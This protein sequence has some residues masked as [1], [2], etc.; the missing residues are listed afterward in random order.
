[1]MDAL[2]H[3]IDCQLNRGV[4]LEDAIRF[5]RPDNLAAIRLPPETSCVAELLSF[6][7]VGFTASELPSQEFI[8]GNVHRSADNSLQRAILNYGG[9]HTANVS[10]FT[11]WPDNSLGDITAQSFR[12]HF[13]DERSHELAI[14]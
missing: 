6:R 3:C 12:H 11:V 5:V 8:L 14:L 13:L 2:H 9:T 4:V 7:Q 10:E 1:R